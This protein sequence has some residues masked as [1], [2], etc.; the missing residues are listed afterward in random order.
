[1]IKG[2]VGV[3]KETFAL[4]FKDLWFCY[5]YIFMWFLVIVIPYRY[6]DSLAG[7]CFNWFNEKEIEFIKK[8]L[9]E[10]PSAKIK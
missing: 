8:T 10:M 9:T 3:F 2:I 4:I 6:L 1:M 7:K 5:K